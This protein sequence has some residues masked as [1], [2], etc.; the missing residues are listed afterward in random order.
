MDSQESVDDKK[1]GAKKT[2]VSEDQQLVPSEKNQPADVHLGIRF[3]AYLVDW[4]LGAL[5]TSLPTALFAQK[6]YGDVTQQN[7]LSFEAP[8]GL[9][10]GALSL[11]CA[12][13][14]FVVLPAFVWEGQTPG[15][16]LFHLKIVAA[17]GSRASLGQ[18][19]LRQVVGIIVVEGALVTA[20]ATLRNVVQLTSG[21]SLAYGLDVGIVVSL[22]S[23]ALLWFTKD[24][25]ALHDFIGTTKVVRA[26]Q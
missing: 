11:L 13:L 14:Y 19:L 12:V 21:V 2:G 1:T 16:R 25:R 17:D 3:I 5:V 4:Y 18:L 23:V 15:K 8:Y 9:I 26:A 6:L 24:H 22:V 20:S 10:A 7:I